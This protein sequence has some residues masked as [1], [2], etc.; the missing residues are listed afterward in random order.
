MIQIK[1]ISYRYPGQKLPVFTNFSLE[2]KENRIYGLL[3]KNGT[4]KSTL[5]YLIAGLLRPQQGSVTCNGISSYRRPA[6]LLEDIFL[7]SEEF[8]LP[9]I[10]LDAYV[11]R[12]C[13]P[14]I[15]A[16]ATTCCSAVWKPSNWV[17]SLICKPSRWDRRRRCI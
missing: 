8:E 12:Y 11:G 4:G 6:E 9:A 2:L 16:S 13:S 3:G 15:H 5:L 10:S 14:S 7:V 1:D 17:R